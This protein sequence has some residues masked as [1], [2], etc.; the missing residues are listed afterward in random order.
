M[1]HYVHMLE[2]EMQDKASVE[3]VANLVMQVS[4]LRMQAPL[5]WEAICVCCMQVRSHTHAHTLTHTHK[6]R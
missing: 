1:S 2:A 3:A 4:W 6:H 5:Q